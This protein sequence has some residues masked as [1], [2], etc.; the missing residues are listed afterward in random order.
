M[1]RTA[2]RPSQRTQGPQR[3]PAREK[4]LD[5]VAG[6]SM[7]GISMKSRSEMG[8]LRIPI[9][10]RRSLSQHKAG[11]EMTQ[12]RRARLRSRLASQERGG[13]VKVMVK[14]MPTKTARVQI[15]RRDSGSLTRD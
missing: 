6:I 11:T 9:R 5:S 8:D 13:G 10:P 2:Q 4:T 3:S 15:S 1:E 14:T 12:G 7:A